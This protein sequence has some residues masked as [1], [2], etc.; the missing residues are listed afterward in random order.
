MPKFILTLGLLFCSLFTFAQQTPPKK[1]D[2]CARLVLEMYNAQNQKLP[3][4]AKPVGKVSFMAR[5][6]YLCNHQEKFKMAK[7]EIYLQEGS[8]TYGR[9]EISGSSYDFSSW[10]RQYKPENR[11]TVMA[12]T[13]EKGKSVMKSWSFKK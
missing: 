6:S 5:H 2:P 9:V 13:A 8:N 3:E 4:G 7:L 1:E 10:E 11:I 12:T